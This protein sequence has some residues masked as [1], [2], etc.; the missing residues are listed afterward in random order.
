MTQAARSTESIEHEECD[1][2]SEVFRTLA[3]ALNDSGANV[4]HSLDASA[5][6][7]AHICAMQM[8]AA[9]DADH[10]TFVANQDLCLNEIVKAINRMERKIVARQAT[11]SIN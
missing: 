11:E 2:V 1:R 3:E 5:H 4:E 7:L 6:L 8:S 10:P 9:I